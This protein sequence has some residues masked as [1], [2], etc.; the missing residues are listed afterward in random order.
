[1]IL[2]KLIIPKVKGTYLVRKDIFVTILY[3]YLLLITGAKV[4]MS[5]RKM[6]TQKPP[7][8]AMIWFSVNAEINIP[9]EI[10]VIPNK[11]R[12]INAQ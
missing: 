9:M 2:E 6:L 8:A 12:P 5:I 11:N 10:R 7:I 3:K 1:M 4:S